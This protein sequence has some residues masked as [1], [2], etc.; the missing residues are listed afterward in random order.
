M[1]TRRAEPGSVR[2]DGKI[3]TGH[4]LAACRGGNAFDLGLYRKGASR[5]TELRTPDGTPVR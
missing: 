4:Q 3:A 5:T 1:N 2:G